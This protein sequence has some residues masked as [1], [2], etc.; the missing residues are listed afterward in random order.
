MALWLRR[1][2]FVDVQCV[3]VSVT[4]I[5]EQRATDWCGGESLSDFLDPTDPSRTI[6]GY[7]APLRAIVIA[8]KPG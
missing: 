7:P 1:A 6:E 4:S 8:R 5:E 3:D 2:G